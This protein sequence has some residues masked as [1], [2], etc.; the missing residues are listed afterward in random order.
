MFSH[1][2]PPCLTTISQLS[3][4]AKPAIWITQTQTLSLN[5]S[6]LCLKRVLCPNQMQTLQTNVAKGNTSNLFNDLAL[7]K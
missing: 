4:K 7:L 5:Q 1:V 6:S 3:L 2:P